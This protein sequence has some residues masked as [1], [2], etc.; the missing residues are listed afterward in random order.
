MICFFMN[1]NTKY[2]L[3]T[4]TKLIPDDLST[5]IRRRCAE[6]SSRLSI[7][8]LRMDRKRR[9]LDKANGRENEKKVDKNPSHSSF[10]VLYRCSIGFPLFPAT[11]RLEIPIISPSSFSDF[12]QDLGIPNLG[13]SRAEVYLPLEKQKSQW[14]TMPGRHV[15][16]YRFNRLANGWKEKGQGRE[17]Q[18][19]IRWPERR[20]R[21]RDE[22]ISLIDAGAWRGAR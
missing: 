21:H 6:N 9:F 5:K 7:N 19:S 1:V 16:M 18:R 12:P 4:F 20:A 8:R 15:P 17:R 13:D 2:L 22:I 10:I 11:R 14:T 3:R